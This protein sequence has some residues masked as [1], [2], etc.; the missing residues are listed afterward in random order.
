M[1]RVPGVR[2]DPV[3]EFRPAFRKIEEIPY[4]ADDVIASMDCECGNTPDT[5]HAS[6][7]EIV[8]FE[9]SVAEPMGL[10]PGKTPC[11]LILGERR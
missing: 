2:D 10:K 4:R 7:E 5:V 1:G 6:K 8:R 9:A 11:H 3:G